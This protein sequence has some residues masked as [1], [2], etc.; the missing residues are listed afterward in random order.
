MT[1]LRLNYATELRYGVLLDIALQ[2]HSGRAVRLSMG[3]L[4]AIWQGD[5]SAMSLESLGCAT[6]PPNVINITGPELL[7]VRWV[8]EEFG[9]RLNK[10]VT[11]EGKESS[12]AL[13]SNAQ[14]SYQLFGRPHVSAQQMMDWIAEWVSKNGGHLSKAHSL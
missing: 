1:I 7:S 4:N 6:S 10:P 8:A 11:F 9:K 14:K 5:A 2:V 3:Y 13:L 12:D